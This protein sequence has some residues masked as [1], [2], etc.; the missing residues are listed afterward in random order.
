MSSIIRVSSLL[1]VAALLASGCTAEMAPDAASSTDEQPG[2][3]AKEPG[4]AGAASS[5]EPVAESAEALSSCATELVC[6]NGQLSVYENSDCS[7]GKFHFC[8]GDYADLTKYTTNLFWFANWN[9]RISIMSTS[10]S[11]H[12]VAVW[13][14]QHV[15]YGGDVR[16]F[17][18]GTWTNLG[19]GLW[20]DQ[21][22][23]LKV[24]A[25]N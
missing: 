6:A 16:Y 7:G 25:V 22:S 21:I 14:Y 24:R 13:A 1:S 15:N 10:G 4:A 12:K 9:D 11:P 2:E 3:T 18:P 19:G 20:N 5:A 8:P 17:A 23:S